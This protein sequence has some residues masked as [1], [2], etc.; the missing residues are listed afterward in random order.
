MAASWKSALDTARGALG[1]IVVFSAGNSRTAGQDVNYHG[2]QNYRGVITVAATN[3]A[4]D[5]ASFSTPGDAI[6]VAAPGVS[7]QTIDRVGAAGYASGDFASLSGTS[8][9]APIVSGVAA[10]ML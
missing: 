3:S 6:L 1:T 5:V 10:L 9:S 2:F 7:I 4:G 8:F